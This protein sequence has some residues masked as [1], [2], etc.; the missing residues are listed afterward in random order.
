M[1]AVAETPGLISISSRVSSGFVGNRLVELAFMRLAPELHLSTIDT[2]QW[3]GPGNDPGRAGPVL[4]GDDLEAMLRRLLDAWHPGDH[5]FLLTGY[6]RTAAQVE[7]VARVLDSSQELDAVFVDPVIADEGKLFVEE[8]TASAIRKV[9]L[10]RAD[11]LLPNLSEALQLAWGN[12]AAV[13]TADATATRLLDQFPNLRGIA[14]KSTPGEVPNRIGVHAATRTH[15]RIAMNERL[16][17]QFHGT[18]D[19][20]AGIL[21]A[22]MLSEPDGGFPSVAM[23]ATTLTDSAL[24][25]WVDG[26]LGGIGEAFRRLPDKAIR[27]GRTPG[28]PAE[29]H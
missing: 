2:V 28:S 10:P 1:P 25:S 20:F 4:S 15:V 5:R 19:L 6:F 29:R 11:Y 18:G 22:I 21:C 16:E 12:P 8:S 3:T 17:G 13:S 24:H 26:N 23:R 7:A 14:I 9:L 27:A